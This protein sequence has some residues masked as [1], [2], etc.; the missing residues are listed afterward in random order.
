[1]KDREEE[2][3][4]SGLS[5][6][7]PEKRTQLLARNLRTR[8]QQ[9][10]RRCKDD[11]VCQ[12]PDCS[13]TPNT[14]MGDVRAA[15]PGKDKGAPGTGYLCPKHHVIHELD[16]SCDYFNIYGKRIRHRELRAG[17]MEV[18]RRVREHME[19]QAARATAAAAATRQAPIISAREVTR[20]Q[21]PPCRE[22]VNSTSV[23]S[24]P[25]WTSSEQQQ[26]MGEVTYGTR[27]RDEQEQMR[28]ERSHRS[29]PRKNPGKW[30]ISKGGW[31]MPVFDG[32]RPYS[33]V[34]ELWVDRWRSLAAEKHL[35]GKS[36]AWAL[37]DFIR[38]PALGKLQR[39]MG[40]RMREVD[41][42]ELLITELRRLY[43][44][45][46]NKQRAMEGF[47]NRNQ[48]KGED[49]RDYTDNLQA[50]FRE[51]DQLASWVSINRAVSQ[52]F[53]ARYS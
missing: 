23:P 34:F 19:R 21:P 36:A 14:E 28:E 40:V 5:P 10:T 46:E 18:R 16:D 43:V 15:I 9:R 44:T 41:D 33:Y 17:L 30:N 49:L 25:H 12:V 6:N 45:K 42:P 53:F 38:N 7:P 37:L 48:S 1:M 51:S 27:S 47:D 11:S 50:L 20:G 3:R 2:N 52:R 4:N 26:S 24:N 13:G 35:T 29:L 32:K 31:K 22:N 39:R 8:S